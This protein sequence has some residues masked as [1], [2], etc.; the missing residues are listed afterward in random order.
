MRGERTLFCSNARIFTPG[1]YMV[2]GFRVENGL[3]SGLIP[4]LTS[5]GTDL[6]GAKVIPGL[7]DIHIHG[8][9]GE[10]SSDGDPEGLLIMGRYLASRGVTA[11]L[12]TLMSL[13]EENTGRALAAVREAMNRRDSTSA[14]ILGARMEGP[15][16]SE[17]RRGAH[18]RAFLRVPDSGMI[19]RLSGGGGLPVRILDLAPELSGAQE[20]IRFASGRCRV[21]LG[22]TAADYETAVSAFDEG[23]SHVTHL[24]NAM[25]PLHHRSPGLIGAAAERENVTAELICDG[26]HIHPSA[27]RLAFRMFP[28]RLCLVSDAIR[29]CGLEGGSYDLGGQSVTVRG[30]EAHLADGTLAGAASDLFTDLSN[31]VRFGADEETAIR[32][33]TLLPARVAGCADLVGS[34][35]AG[36]RADFLICGEDLSLREVYIAG[37]RIR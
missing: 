6:G 37:K 10:D 3:F 15:F 13:P 35:E 31:A 20:F 7:V 14:R 28:E 21:S 9:A 11:F 24:F 33:V 22:H 36:R 8:A 19:V 18:N 27:V 2:G 30:G 4:G 26:V 5:G 34:I 1:G 12:P 29:C 17:E 25:S 16:L 32:A 23:A